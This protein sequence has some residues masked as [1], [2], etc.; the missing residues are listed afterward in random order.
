MTDRRDFI[1]TL[2]TGGAALVAPA[3]SRGHSTSRALSAERERADDAWAQ[4]PQILKRIKAPAFPGRY[5]D[6]TRYGA[7]GD[8]QKDCTQAFAKAINACGLAGGGTVIVPAGSFLTGAIHLKS[9]VNLHVASGATVKFSRD[10]NKYLPLVFTRWEGM[11]LMNYS[12]LI[13]AF[14]Q[15]DR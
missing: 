6:I 4:V 13:Y 7:A 9:N 1:R 3:L 10:P 2:L 5:F 11:E 15:E 12:P 14:E 8:G